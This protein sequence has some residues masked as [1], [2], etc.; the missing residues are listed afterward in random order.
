LR[1]DL[2]D[3]AA[4]GPGAGHAGDEIAAVGI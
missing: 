3:A 1:Q 4:H 2:R